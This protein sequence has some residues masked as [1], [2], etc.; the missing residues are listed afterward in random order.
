MKL[1]IIVQTNV[2]NR[3]LV[4]E[5]RDM[6]KLFIG[7]S[8]PSQNWFPDIDLQQYAGQ[9]LGVSRRHAAI[10]NRGDKLYI[11]DL[12]SPNGTYVNQTVLF[13]LQS[14]ALKSRDIVQVGRISLQVILES[15]T[16]TTHKDIQG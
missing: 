14:H 15:P 10:S 16:S 7:R 8:D 12:G 1:V 4:F 3:P 9:L 11:L 5:T 6:N 13:P 2:E